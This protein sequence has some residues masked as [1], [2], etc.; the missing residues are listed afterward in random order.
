MSPVTP[1]CHDRVAAGAPWIESFEA[2]FPRVYLLVTGPPQRSL[3]QLREGQPETILGSAAAPPR[4][5]GP[6]GF[7]PSR[8]GELSS[9][10]PVVTDLCAG[11]EPVERRGPCR[12][13]DAVGMRCLAA[14]ASRSGRLADIAAA[15]RARLLLWSSRPPLAPAGTER[16]PFSRECARQHG[17]RDYR[18]PN[19]GIDR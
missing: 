11:E 2:R 1:T 14:P 7:D 10:G 9:A 6:R 4:W 19:T 12:F 17:R 5:C 8:S 13:V 18:P 15:E 16:T 3:A